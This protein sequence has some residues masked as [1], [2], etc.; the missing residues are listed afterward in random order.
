M[1][2][3]HA[4][5]ATDAEYELPEGILW[6]DR[7]ALVRWVDIWKGRV[8]SGALRDGRIVDITSTELGQTAGAVALAEDGGLLVAAARGLATISA[9][10]AVSFGPDL[11][12]ERAR[13]A[14]QRRL[15]RPAGPIRRRHARA[16]RRDRRRGPAARLADGAVETLRTGIRLSNG[17]AFSP[18]GGTIYHVDTLAEHGVEPLLRPRAR[19]ISTSR[20]SPCS[21][22][23]PTSPTA[24]PSTR[25]HAVGRAVGRFERPPPRASPASCSTSSRSTRRRPRARR[26]SAPTWPPSRSPPR[27]RA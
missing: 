27:R 17:I 21:R 9:D 23:S 1:S 12:G 15:G 6:D 20:G 19:S 14:L 18:D 3:F 8:L 13:R 11:L 16:R 24:S 5:P 4:E 10:G 25:R 7:A 26:S 2:T 22:T